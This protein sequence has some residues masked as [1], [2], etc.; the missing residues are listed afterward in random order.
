MTDLAAYQQLLQD[1]V[2]LSGDAGFPCEP[3]EVHASRK[4]FQR[5]VTAWGVRGGRRAFFLRFGL[6][7]TG[8][9]LE[10]GRLVLEKVKSDRNVLQGV[11]FK[12]GGKVDTF[13]P[14][15]PLR[16]LIGTTLDARWEF[17]LEAAV[18]GIGVKFVRDDSE[19]TEDGIYLTNYESI[20]EG[21]VTPS[22]FVGVSLDEAAVLRSFGSKTFGEMNFGAWQDVPYR[23]V[24]TA[25][26]DPNEHLELISYAHFLGVMDMGE[27]KTR[28]F[29]RDSEH[30][31]NLTLH[32]H[33]TSEFWLWV[34]SWAIFVQKPSDLG[35]SDEGYEMPPLDV[36][37][38][39]IPTDHQRAGQEKSGQG[40]MLNDTAKGIAGASREKRASLAARIA[41]MLEI[42][43]E[44]PSAHRIIWHDLEDERHAIE[45]ALPYCVSVYGS[46]DLEERSAAIADFAQGKIR[47]LAAKPVMLG[48]GVNLQKHCHL[49]IYLGI[50]FKFNDFIQSVHRLRRYLQTDTVRIDLIYTEAERHVRHTLEDK[51]TQYEIMVKRMTDIIR[52][53]GLSNASKA[54][55]LSRSIGVPR[56][57]VEG[58]NWKLINND[59]V[60][61]TANMPDN[62]VGLI[63]T[64][65]P[66]SSQ[67]EYTP[68]YNDFGHTDDAPHF[69][70]QMSFLIPELLRVLKPGRVAAVHVKDRVVP[71]AITGLGYQSIQ[72]FHADAIN[73]FLHYKFTYMGMKTVVTD[74][75]REN[76]QTYRL[77]WGEQCKDGSRM[78]CGLPEYV[79]LFRKPPTN[80]GQGYADE[81]VVHTKEE[82]SRAR[83]QFDAHG[84]MRSSGDRLLTVEDMRGLK[85]SQIYQIFKE[86]SLNMVYDFERDVKIAEAADAVGML[87]PSYM[88][89]QPQSW[90]PEVWTDV[91]R[92]KTM[93]SLQS[94]QGREKH[95]CPLQ[96]DICDRIIEQY[97]NKGDIVYDPFS[98][99]GT[100]P[101]RAVK[102]GRQGWGTELNPNY[103]GDG[104][105]H[106][107]AEERKAKT[108]TLFDLVKM[109]A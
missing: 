71:G 56:Q 33:K 60:E 109:E 100:V 49:A 27:A 103:H 63:L 96:F 88:L 74:V 80:S 22:Q 67:Y 36:R 23:F 17:L 92:F 44:E 43:N 78:G 108:M 70:Q 89:L 24:A 48:S 52:Q 10:T 6:G 85:G 50:S 9:Q 59:T 30:A 2:R 106:L 15:R 21:K 104:V 4:D 98:G 8:I 38:H 72:P 107:R 12:D 18:L 97:S 29:H 41:R 105:H 99:I 81:R 102:K 90:N 40:R 14:Q 55:A 75:V 19:I 5:D 83:W 13:K 87:P 11:T 3:G 32:P 42:R 68:S 86:L 57:E 101:L 79:L 76:A 39:E 26:P 77:G 34:A 66:F 28:F 37:W 73:E 82:Y 94:S 35:Y 69:W 61:E 16:F 45:E 95:I 20:R 58:S 46:Q 47:E 25:C 84:F 65:I 53:Y 54:H 64:S 62:S 31:D 93:N 91:V 51:W 7:K 1:K